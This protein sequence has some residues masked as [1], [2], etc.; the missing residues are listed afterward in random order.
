MSEKKEKKKKKEKKRKKMNS[1]NPI[2]H[3]LRGSLIIPLRII[4]HGYS[5]SAPLPRLERVQQRTKAI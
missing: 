3:P 5:D 2:K 1:R 4:L